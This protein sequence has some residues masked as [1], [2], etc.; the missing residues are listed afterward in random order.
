MRC[1]GGCGLFC[2]IQCQAV[3]A[4]KR[5]SR[6]QSSTDLEEQVSLGCKLPPLSTSDLDSKEHPSW[7]CRRCDALVGSRVFARSDD[8]FF[9]LGFVLARDPHGQVCV[10]FESRRDASQC[11]Q[12]CPGGSTCPAIDTA[13]TSASDSL[14]ATSSTVVILPAVS[15]SSQGAEIGT[16]NRPPKVAK[17]AKSR[18]GP[19]GQDVA[20]IAI[21]GSVGKI[22][23]WACPRCTLINSGASKKCKLCYAVNPISAPNV[24]TAKQST[25]D[26]IGLHGPTDAT[27][28]ALPAEATDTLKSDH[29]DEAGEANNTGREGIDCPTSGH[30]ESTVRWVSERHAAL[31]DHQA[32]LGEMKRGKRALAIWLDGHGYACEVT[33]GAGRGKVTVQFEDG[34]LYDVDA[35]NLRA[36]LD[37]PLFVSVSAPVESSSSRLRSSSRDSP[38]VTAWSSRAA[39]RSIWCSD[40]GHAG[41]LQRTISALLRVWRSETSAAD[42]AIER[43]EVQDVFIVRDLLNTEEVR[44]LR[45]LLAAHQGWSMYNWGSIGR[46]A[47][48]ASVMQRIDFGLPEMTAEGVAAQSNTVQ[49]IGELQ[50][51][52]IS[53]LE[54]RLRVAFGPVAWG[55]VTTGEAPALSPNMMQFTR[56]APHTCL[57]NHFDRRDKWQEG[58]A[59]IAWSD[60]EGYEDP[61]GDPY[62]LQMQLGPPG[63]SQRTVCTRLPAG[64]AYILTGRAQGRTEV[65]KKHCVAHSMCNC[66][67]THGIWN[68]HSCRTRE[69]ITLRVF[70]TEW[71]RVKGS[72]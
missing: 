54:A 59:S 28:A 31:A 53:L 44:A 2:H 39:V 15:V 10:S 68:E 65:C 56:I 30:S 19:P 46:K 27:E 63:A 1:N 29:G 50:L 52:I 16:S 14:P 57:G 67:W 58:I 20:A 17:T 70:D 38:T 32:S 62:V 40:S 4:I 33:G 21:A 60:G 34:M 18:Q 71:G 23:R 36:L 43:G 12:A 45:L 3:D 72:T 8:G 22:S 66:C 55:G 24:V 26:G 48:L 61:R 5:E 69:S 47:E 51:Q 13:M 35:F 64:S 25:D 37:E 49:P 11:H 7:R 42:W 6:E 41:P 9:R